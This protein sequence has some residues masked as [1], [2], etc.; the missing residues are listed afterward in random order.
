MCKYDKYLGKKELIN[1]NILVDWIR[2]WRQ[3]KANITS[4]FSQDSK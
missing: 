4:F 1:L 3:G 2:C